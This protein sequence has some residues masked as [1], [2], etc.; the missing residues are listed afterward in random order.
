MT[1]K[2]NKFYKVFLFIKPYE[3]EIISDT[4]FHMPGIIAYKH[5]RTASFGKFLP[6]T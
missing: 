5:M 2:S 6:S 4:T 3:Q 1:S